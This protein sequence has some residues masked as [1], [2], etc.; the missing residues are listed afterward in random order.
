[1]WIIRGVSE[2]LSFNV[3]KHV[4]NILETLSEH[5]VHATFFITGRVAEKH[6]EILQKI[7]KHDHE[8]GSHSYAHG[9][10]SE[11]SRA[12]AK[13]DILKSITVLSKYQEVRGFRAPFLVRNRATYLACEDLNMDYDS[14]EYGLMKYRPNGFK[15]LVIPVVSPLDTHGLDLMHFKP[16][17]LVSEWASECSK[18]V[19]AA[20]CMHVWRIGRKKYIKAILEPLLESGMTFVSAHELLSANGIAFTFDVEYTSFGEALPQNLALLKSPGWKYP[21][22]LQVRSFVKD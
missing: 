13:K 18:S 10:F 16:E 7:C 2:R 20:I 12:D 15:V 3:H 4:D 6:P 17:E 8:I 1:M 5:G 11:M 19:G 21:Q 9:D 14:S 22:S